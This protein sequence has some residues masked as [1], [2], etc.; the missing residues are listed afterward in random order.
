MKIKKLLGAGAFLLAAL[1]CTIGM[2]KPAY[3]AGDS[4]DTINKG[5][6][7]GDI[8]AGGMTKQEAQD[9]I[10]DYIAGLDKEA[11]TLR[12]N[13]EEMTVTAGQLGLKLSNEEILDE[14]LSLG[15]SGNIV[16]R[17]K[18]LKDLEHE[19]KVYELRV[20]PDEQSVKT[21]V[22]EECT[23]FNVDAENA[24]LEK[25]GSTFN[26][27][28]GKTGLKVDVDTSVDLILDYISNEWDHGT[29]QLELAV[30]V[31]EPKG[32]AE[33]LGRVKDLLGSFSTSFPNSSSDRVTNVSSGAKHINASVIYPG[34]EFSV[35]GAV[36]PF[37]EKNGYRMAG[38]YENGMV[39]DSLG[40]GICQVSTTLYNA[41]IRAELEVTERSPHSM[42]VDYVQPSMDAAIAGTYKDLKFKNNTDAPI[43][44]E[45]FTQ[46]KTITFNI[47]GEE[48]R[49]N[50]RK[51]EFVSETLETVD[52]GT[53]IIGDPALPAG[54]KKTTQ[55]AHKGCTAQLWK[56]VYENGT[57][58]SREIFNKSK[59]Q[60]SP[61]YITIGLATE[62]G[63]LAQQLQDAVTVSD[64]AYLNAVLGGIGGGE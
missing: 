37:T 28:P 60:P 52:P 17:Y 34:D 30:E 56:V 41:V 57:E 36:S 24:G 7:L 16:Q 58:V 64:E 15:K 55:S 4:G 8:D 49:S 18:A 6:F 46:G 14:A 40:G 27:I 38:A 20:E 53:K 3:A 31:D 45:G 5:V 44:I 9:A 29:G 11:I 33:Q 42:L 43:Y 2:E 47:Y 39:V 22:E 61:K 48:Y 54:Y 59:Y 12:I 21:L 10:D 32:T 62:D 23:K 35:Y 50:T 13:E 19:Q 51:I 26:V 63:N 25:N 1:T